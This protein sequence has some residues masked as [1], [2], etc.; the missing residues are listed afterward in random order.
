MAKFYI[1]SGSIAKVLLAATAL[2]AVKRFIQL[3]ISEDRVKTCELSE[4]IIVSERGFYK[5]LLSGVMEVDGLSIITP[6]EI[7]SRKKKCIRCEYCVDFR[8]K[9]PDEDV[10]F[11]RDDILKDV[12]Y[13]L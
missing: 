9:E 6:V 10:M 7:V 12:G 5:D 2:D 11:M 3:V 8:D 1:Q 13:L 4:G